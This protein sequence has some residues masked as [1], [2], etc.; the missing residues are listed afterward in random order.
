MERPGAGRG[1]G[2]RG[3]RADAARRGADAKRASKEGRSA[4]TLLRRRGRS[5]RFGCCWMRGRIRTRSMRRSEATR[6]HHAARRS[7]SLGSPGGRPTADR[8]WRNVRL[9][10]DTDHDMLRIAVAYPNVLR[11]LL[12]AGVDLAAP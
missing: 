8:S 10:A 5:S 12:D 11:I 4:Y 7:R 3:D 6:R 1:V 9:P 2:G